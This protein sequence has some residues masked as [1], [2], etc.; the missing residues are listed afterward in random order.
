MEYE[1]LKLRNLNLIVNEEV[2]NRKLENITVI[3]IGYEDMANN[4]RNY[5]PVKPYEG[6]KRD[7]A[8]KYLGEY[9]QQKVAP[10]A[11][12]REVIL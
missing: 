5:I 6:I 4:I 2:H 3:G 8:L 7:H 10:S 9:L 12:S 1:H 11:D